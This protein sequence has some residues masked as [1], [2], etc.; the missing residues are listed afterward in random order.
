[1]NMMDDGHT[2]VQVA[3]LRHVA[4]RGHVGLLCIRKQPAA[5]GGGALLPA[6][7]D[8][9]LDAAD[10]SDLVTMKWVHALVVVAPGSVVQYVDGA[11]VPADALGFDGRWLDGGLP[12]GCAN[13]A[14]CDGSGGAR[15][16]SLAPALR[17]FTLK[18]DVCAAPAQR[19]APCIA[20]CGALGRAQK[21]RAAGLLARRAAGT[22]AG[23][24]TS[25]PTGTSRGR[26]RGCSS[27]ARPSAPA[28]PAAS[29]RWCAIAPPCPSP[30]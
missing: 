18:T 22:S 11:A 7:W 20:P 16:G 13:N 29:T 8:Y 23:G 3:W 4:L 24:T 10:G 30:R 17:G 15:L 21:G 28:R 12:H 6:Q 26:W 9:L 19:G 27:A 2:A 5:D 14:A 1:M 25:G